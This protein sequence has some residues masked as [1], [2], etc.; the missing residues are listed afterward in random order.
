MVVPTYLSLDSSWH[1]LSTRSLVQV[2]NPR[3]SIYSER[4]IWRWNL[5]LE[6]Q[7]EQLLL[8]TYVKINIYLLFTFKFFGTDCM[9]L[10]LRIMF[11]QLS[12]KGETWDEIDF[13]F[14]GNVT[15]QP[16]VLHT[17]VFTGGKGN[18][19]MQFYLW[20]DPT[21]DSHTYTVLWTLLTSCK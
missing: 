4:L 5:L 16:Y 3:K 20:F 6:T 19:E 13:E 9:I 7:P 21:A 18:R 12:S 2:F 15:G 17:N 8:T 10:I 11:S 14:L 1:A